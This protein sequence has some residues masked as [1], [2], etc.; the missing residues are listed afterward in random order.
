MV[1]DPFDGDDS[2]GA[3]IY[4]HESDPE[5]DSEKKE[6]HRDS[7]TR[8]LDDLSLFEDKESEAEED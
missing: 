1:F 6:P 7:L 2:L 4:E 3:W 5:A 8:P